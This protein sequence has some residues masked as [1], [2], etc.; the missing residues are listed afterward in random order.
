M[1]RRVLPLVAA[2][3]AT[4][5]AQADIIYVDAADTASGNTT[6]AAGG[7][8]TG[9]AQSNTPNDGEWDKRAFGNG[10]TIFQNA[11]TTAGVDT[12]AVRLATSVSGLAPD[13][14]NAYAYFW[15]DNSTTWRLGASL[16]DDVGQL[17]VYQP[18]D[19]GVSQYYT[20]GDATVLSSS[21][22]VNPFTTDVMIAEGNRRLYEVSL[23]TFTGTGFTV[24][25]EGDS[26]MT[27]QDQ[28][29]W[30]DGI[31]YSVVPEP[32]TLALAGLGLA[33]LL[34]AEI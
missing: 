31:G 30:Y 25:I 24:F 1:K 27:G 3:M 8:F 11:G 16:T 21:L 14:Y 4:S 33:G 32:S 26:S 7:V 17:T 2:L 29:T 6:L 5:V 15:S 13:T 18:G 19:A 9:I 28:R 23:G 34:T 12:N 20:G 22:G 10:A